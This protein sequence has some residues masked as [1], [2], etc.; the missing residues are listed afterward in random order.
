MKLIFVY[1]LINLSAIT[2]AYIIFVY[3]YRLSSNFAFQRTPFRPLSVIPP[4]RVII[5]VSSPYRITAFTIYPTMTRLETVYSFSSSSLRIYWSRH[6][7]KCSF[8][9]WLSPYPKTFPL[10]A[11]VSLPLRCTEHLNMN[12]RI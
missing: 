3:S 5:T 1:Y 12:L 7:R 4:T 9:V 11:L 10:R 6:E 2:G 8:V